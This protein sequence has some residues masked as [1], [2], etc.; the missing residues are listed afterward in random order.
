MRTSLIKIQQLE[1]WLLNQGDLPGRLVTEAE[2]LIDHN[3][4]EDA[5]WQ[6]RSY[7]L[8]RMFGQE[9][10]HEEIQAV[11]SSL[12]EDPKHYTFQSRIRSIFKN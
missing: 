4:Q 6:R 12:F 9:K 8:I 3:L 10:L 5:K 1:N 11:E 2:L 7:E